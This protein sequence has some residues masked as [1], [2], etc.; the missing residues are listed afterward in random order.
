MDNSLLRDYINIHIALKEEC[1]DMAFALLQGFKFTGIEE[2]FDEIV[3]SYLATD[4]TDEVR[5]E[6]MSILQ[7][8]DPEAFIINEETF[9]EKNW[10]EEWEKNVEPIVVSEN[11]VITP[12]WKKDDFDAKYKIELKFAV[13][14]SAMEQTP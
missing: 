2:K 6:L 11:I 8:L 9:A 3:V 10:N 5:I 12:E 4:W 1:F 7:S 14:H 13:S